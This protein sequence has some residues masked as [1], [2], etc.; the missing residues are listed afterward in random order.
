MCS[1]FLLWWGWR[2]FPSCD[3][4]MLCCITIEIDESAIQTLRSIFV[5]GY[6][7]LRYNNKY[8]E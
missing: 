2:T 1:S 6:E 4:E 8:T 7:Y 5:A 3:G